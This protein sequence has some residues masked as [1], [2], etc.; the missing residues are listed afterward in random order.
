MY[1]HIADDDISA[2]RSAYGRTD[3]CPGCS[4][5]RRT[6]STSVGGQHIRC[7]AT[8]YRHGCSAGHGDTGVITAACR[9]VARHMDGRIASGY[10]NGILP[11]QR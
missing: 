3:A 10:V 5:A 1:R 9:V 4:G 7:A 8:F 6:S 11:P 2:L